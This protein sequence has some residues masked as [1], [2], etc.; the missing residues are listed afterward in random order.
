MAQA[1]LISAEHLSRDAGSPCGGA[2]WG[3][4]DPASPQFVVTRR[5]LGYL[6]NA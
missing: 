1:E 4:D 6:F 3:A 2:A 5:G